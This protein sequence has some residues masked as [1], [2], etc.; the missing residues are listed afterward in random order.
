MIEGQ[1]FEASFFG[2]FDDQQ[3][4]SAVPSSADMDKLITSLALRRSNLRLD[5]EQNL[6]HRMPS[7]RSS[8][9]H[10]GNVQVRP[11]DG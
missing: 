2:F 6:I 9:T 8:A 4:V 5:L 10:R 7:R 1:R 11:M 3:E